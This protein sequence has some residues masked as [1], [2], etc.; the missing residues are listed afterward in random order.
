M[1]GKYWQQEGFGA[2]SVI[3]DL[4]CKISR[5]RAL[6]KSIKNIDFYGIYKE[7]RIFFGIK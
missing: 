1:R 7:Y 4:S 5:S 6:K 3:V 2:E